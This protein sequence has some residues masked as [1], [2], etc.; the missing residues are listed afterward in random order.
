[1]FGIKDEIFVLNNELKRKREELDKLDPKAEENRFKYANVKS[2]IYILESKIARLE[3][4]LSQQK[5][6]TR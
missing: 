4:E 6:T 1:M 3:E 5:S 2:E